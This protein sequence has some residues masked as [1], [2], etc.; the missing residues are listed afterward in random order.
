MQLKRIMEREEIELVSTPFS[1]KD[2]YNNI[3]KALVSGFFMQ[4]AMKDTSG[5]TYVTVKD[6][7]SVL[8]HPSTVL[9]QDSDWVLYNEFVLTSKNYIRTV[10]AVKPEWLLDIAEGYYDLDSFKKGEIKTSLQRVRDKMNRRQAMAGNG[11]RI[12]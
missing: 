7:Q 8:L 11:V 12:W 2:Y 10:T 3:R 6:D 9:G 1:D 5:K 4:I